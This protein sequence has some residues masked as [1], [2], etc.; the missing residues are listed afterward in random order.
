MRIL[1]YIFVFFTFG[2][3][4][5]ELK[6]Q[7]GFNDAMTNSSMDSIELNIYN[8]S[9]RLF[10]GQWTQNDDVISVAIPKNN[11]IR[12]KAKKPGYYTL[13]TLVNLNDFHK[14]IKKGKVM[15]IEL[16]MSYDGQ[17]TTDFEVTATYR[18]EI[19]F[20]SEKISVSDFVVINDSSMILL[21]YPKRLNHESELIFFVDDSIVS[22]R[23]VPENAIRL[24]TDYRTRIYL[25]CEFS[26]FIL[27]KDEFLN[28]TIVSREQLDN[29][30]R[31]ILDTL[32]NDQLFFTTHKSHYPAFDFFKVQMQDTTHSLI[33]HIEDTEMMEFYRAEY[34]WADVRTQLWA[35]DK[36]RETG[37]DR[38]IWVGANVFTNSIYYE[39]PYSEMFLVDD[40]VYVFDFYQSMMFKYDANSGSKLDSV[41]IDFHKDARKTGWERRMI[42]DPVTKN[43][44][45]MYDES[46][47][48]DIHKIDLSNGQIENKFTLFYRY[49]ENVQIFN[50]QVFYV[51]R[52]F[53]SMQKK[54]LYYEGFNDINRS[55]AGQN[56]FNQFKN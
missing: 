34:K 17:I 31:P 33:H 12:L 19:A 8:N 40:L 36:E 56:R 20:S 46:G 1:T 16:E 47:Y 15:F 48:S 5:Q 53:E 43:I 50:D 2:T 30:V 55:L 7:L 39:A 4:A 28:L 32:E 29:Y 27:S 9:M 25:R 14:N 38:E 13:D 23:K 35:W 37:I 24:D 26:D 18:P 54:F 52:P 3:T 6:L 51:Y 22:R 11:I 41:S 44:Y 10:T 42:Q 45:T 21:T 49:V